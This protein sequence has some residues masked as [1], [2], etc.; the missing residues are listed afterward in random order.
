MDLKHLFTIIQAFA[1]NSHIPFKEETWFAGILPAILSNTNLQ[2]IK[3]DSR[4]WF[5]LQLMILGHYD[6]NAIK[7]VL[8]SNYLNEFLARKGISTMDL[9]QILI[10]YQTAA[11][12]STN[13]ISL[14]DTKTIINI[15]KCYAARLPVCHIQ[16]A[17]LEELGPDR[18]LRNVKTKYYHL[19]PTL[20]KM[21]K[22]ELHF[23]SFAEMDRD[24]NGFVALEDVT[25]GEN[26][27]L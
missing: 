9:H 13:N 4:F 17:L 7:I 12:Q 20:V 22:K 1:N 19:I 8:N 16:K 24:A 25:C 2:S 18:I 15:F 6:E 21:N 10:F 26:E 3:A 14:V 23:E 27:L 5:T 11:M